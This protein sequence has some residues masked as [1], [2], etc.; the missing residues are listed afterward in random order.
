MGK[1]KLAVFIASKVFQKMGYESQVAV[2]IDDID[3]IMFEIKT[4]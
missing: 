4:A 2:F 1:C 3:P